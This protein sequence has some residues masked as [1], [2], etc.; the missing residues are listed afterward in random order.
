MKNIAIIMRDQIDVAHPHRVEPITPEMTTDDIL[1]AELRHT[2]LRQEH[3]KQ[4]R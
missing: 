4:V 3:C 2:R 1:A